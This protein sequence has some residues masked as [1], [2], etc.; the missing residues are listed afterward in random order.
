MN[1]IYSA[2]LRRMRG[3]GRAGFSLATVLVLVSVLAIIATAMVALFTT[4]LNFL[5][6]SNNGQVALDEA[7]AGLNQVLLNLAADPDYGT[8][9]ETL[10]RTLH[11]GFASQECYHEV[12]FATSQSPHSTNARNGDTT[13]YLGRPV[14]SECVHVISTGFCRGQIRTLEAIIRQ[15]PFNFAL[16]S[17]GP[18]VS[19]N[20]LRVEGIDS[21]QAYVQGASKPLPGHVASNSSQGINISDLSGLSSYISGQARASGAVN[22][23]SNA[24]VVQGIRANAANLPLPSISVTSFDP[25]GTAG[26]Q[27][28]TTATS[29][30]GS[31]AATKRCD[32]STTFSNAV[33][34][35]NGLLYL[36]GD[37]TFDR[38]LTGSGAIIVDGDVTIRGAGTQLSGS[39]TV[40]ILSSGKVKIEGDPNQTVTASANANFINGLVYGAK[41][42]D[43]SNIT[44]AGIVLTQDPQST[45]QLTNTNLMYVSDAASLDIRIAEQI[46]SGGSD[47]PPIFTMPDGSYSI[48]LPPGAQ[49]GDFPQA[50]PPLGMSMQQH[51]SNLMLTNPSQVQVGR[52]TGS[53]YDATIGGPP[54]AALL[55]SWVSTGTIGSIPPADVQVAIGQLLNGTQ[56][57]SQSTWSVTTPGSSFKL[58]L[59]NFLPRSSTLRVTGLCL[60]HRRL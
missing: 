60:H 1:R 9:G 48:G 54:A 21:R 37:V 47:L 12:S 18:I 28:I 11:P 59:N 41:G 13:G 53:G 57:T 44:V 6:A 19:A 33:N 55:D 8:Q 14:A 43:L 30:L 4:N 34:F 10:R 51:L 7:E 58:D 36:A 5:Q 49:F 20:P 22:L 56:P 50:N 17:A 45:T 38:G 29:T 52:L 26:L 40:A 16:A 25:L 32:Q 3:R 27:R 42:V 31:L 46:D 15:P 39:D 35:S 24:T 2:I 23:D